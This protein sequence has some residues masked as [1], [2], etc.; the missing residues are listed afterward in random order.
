VGVCLAALV[1]SELEFAYRYFF[2]TFATIV[3]A[4]LATLALQTQERER[5]RRQ[6]ELTAARLEIELLKKHLQP[7]FLMNTLT[8]AI[9]WLEAEPDTGAR[10]VEALAHELRLLG[11]VSAQQAISVRRELDLCR[12]HLEVM[13]YR[14]DRTFHLD[15]EGL[16]P[17]ATV[18]PA[19][20]HTLLEN[21][22]THNRYDAAH[23]RFQLRETA[24]DGGR[25]YTFSAPRTDDA[26][27]FGDAPASD[28]TAR[29]AAPNDAFLPPSS[30][31]EGDWAP[32]SAATRAVST[33]SAPAS[34]KTAGSNGTGL[35]YVKAR[36]RECYGDAWA[37][38][39]GPGTD[40]DGAPVWR[41]TITIYD[42]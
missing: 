42:A 40:G 21:A 29:D 32:A 39:A 24:V 38:R 26:D 34:E 25:R 17:G 23:V 22:L 27:A 3:V 19:L 12:L 37:L 31:D 16:T 9:E 10:F 11:E 6:A 33:A 35:R 20:F 8:A 2:P 7:H 4:L 30:G 1:A 5:R 15:T 13:G 36:L 18:P 28:T 14:Q 41:T